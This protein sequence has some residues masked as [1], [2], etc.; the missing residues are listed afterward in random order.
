M[1][2]RDFCFWLQGHFE[3]NPGAPMTAEQVDMVKR[4][5]ALVFKHEIDPAMGGPEKQAELNVTHAG[6]ESDPNPCPSPHMEPWQQPHR[7]G[8]NVMR[9]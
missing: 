9:C 6:K 3:L 2:S 8:K 4:H 1:T 5:L 7:P